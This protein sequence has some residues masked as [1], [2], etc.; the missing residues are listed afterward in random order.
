[1]E[2]AAEEEKVAPK[3]NSQLFCMRISKL[4]ELTQLKEEA[5][6]TLIMKIEQLLRDDEEVRFRVLPT[7]H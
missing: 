7:S 5:I 2:A 1:M 6:L 4:V 3:V